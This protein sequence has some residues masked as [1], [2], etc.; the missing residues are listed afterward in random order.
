[1]HRP[2]HADPGSAVQRPLFDGQPKRVDRGGDQRGDQAYHGAAFPDG[3]RALPARPGG[4]R[5]R[6]R[7]GSG[8]R[9]K[10]P[11]SARTAVAGPGALTALGGPVPLK[12]ERKPG[13][14]T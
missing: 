3:G 6:V 8:L 7:R 13:C 1:M 11:E 5:P 4:P 12:P 2:V 14:R 9:A 10:V